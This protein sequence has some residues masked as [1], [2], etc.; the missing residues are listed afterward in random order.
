MLPVQ[1]ASTIN[2]GVL[3]G[4]YLILLLML[5][6]SGMANT[7]IKHSYQS[8][9][10]PYDATRRS[11]LTPFSADDKRKQQNQ[12]IFWKGIYRPHSAAQTRFC[13]LITYRVISWVL[14][15]YFN[16]LCSLLT[17]CIDMQAVTAKDSDLILHTHK[18]EFKTVILIS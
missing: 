10:P 1:Y 16:I 14:M 15:L 17:F 9:C 4:Q 18:N 2:I 7:K 12:T 5:Q 6:H 11:E 8:I 3:D 13:Y